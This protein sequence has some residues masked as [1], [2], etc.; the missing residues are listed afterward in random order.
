MTRQEKK[1]F[2][3]AYLEA[4]LWSSTTD[5]GTPL[6]EGRD[7]TDIADAERRKAIRDC[8]QFIAANERALNRAGTPEQNG[9][10]YWLT[11][12]HHGAGFWDRGYPSKIGTAL[13]NAA[14]AEGRRDLYI[15]DDNLIYGF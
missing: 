12:N 5:D 9:H 1:Q 7:F 15:A 4:A 13:T 3:A 10:D 11:R 2:V 14:H 8:L 6:D